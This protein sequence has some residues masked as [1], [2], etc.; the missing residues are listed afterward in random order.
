LQQIATAL[1]VP[2]TFFYE[3]NSKERE[4]ESLLFLD[5]SF[6][7]QLLRAYTAVENQAVQRQFVSL[8]E[9]NVASQS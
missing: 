5:S 6:T 4:V 3:G 2:V 8:I 7:L 1:D 9:S